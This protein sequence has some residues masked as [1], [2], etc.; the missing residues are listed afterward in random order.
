MAPPSFLVAIS[1]FSPFSFRRPRHHQ[2]LRETSELSL[3]AVLHR[4]RAKPNQ[5][6]ESIAYFSADVKT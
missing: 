3:H 6:P 4:I 5:L 1:I 2:L